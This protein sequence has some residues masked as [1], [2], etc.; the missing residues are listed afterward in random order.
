MKPKALQAMAAMEES[1]GSNPRSP[2]WSLIPWFDPMPHISKESAETHSS[3]LFHDP[4]AGS[5]KLDQHNDAKSV[6]SV[7]LGGNHCMTR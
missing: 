2:G 3:S 4:S 5:Q 7:V 6:V 1:T